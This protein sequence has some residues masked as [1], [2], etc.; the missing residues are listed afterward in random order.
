MINTLTDVGL[1]LLWS[2]FANTPI[3]DRDEIEEEFHLWEAET[4]RFEIWKWFDEQHSKGV[5]FLLGE[6]VETAITAQSI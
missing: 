6:N 2:E 1:E 5:A 3:N 4:N